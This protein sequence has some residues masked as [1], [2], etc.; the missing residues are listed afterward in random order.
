MA[1]RE[2]SLPLIGRYRDCSCGTGTGR[3]VSTDTDL[4]VREIPNKAM[5]AHRL[6][7]DEREFRMGDTCCG[8]YDNAPHRAPVVRNQV[9]ALFPDCGTL[10]A[11]QRPNITTNYIT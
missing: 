6:S 3:G 4:L 11:L 7:G 9:W 2:K 8:V 5:L 1:N 10:T